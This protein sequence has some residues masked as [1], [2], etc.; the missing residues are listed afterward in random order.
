[1]DDYTTREM[2]LT[3]K[4]ITPES[5][6]Y[7]MGQQRQVFRYAIPKHKPEVRKLIGTLAVGE[8]YNMATTKLPSTWI[9]TNAKLLSTNSKKTIIRAKLEEMN[10][11][12]DDLWGLLNG[13]LLS[14]P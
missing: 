10:R 12:V 1:M 14:D 9:W 6:M 7:T 5:V 4:E 8:T 2:V 11:V 3:V 13:G